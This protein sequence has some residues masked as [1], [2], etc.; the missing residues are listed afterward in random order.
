[1]PSSSPVPCSPFSPATYRGFSKTISGGGQNLPWFWHVLKCA[2]ISYAFTKSDYKTV[3]LPV[4]FYGLMAA[5]TVQRAQILPLI[6]WVWIHLLQFN[7]AN[8]M[9]N[10]EEDSLNKPYRPIPSGLITAQ[11]TRILRWI[12][13]PVCLGISWSYNVFSAGISL[14]LAFIA[15]NEFGLDNYWYTKNFLNA[16][17]LVS[18][19]VGATTIIS[20]AESMQG[21]WLAPW[22]S[23]A[24]I[25]ST[26]HIQDFRD[27]V[28]DKQQGRT[29]FPVVMPEFSRLASSI[30]ILVWSVILPVYCNPNIPAAVLLVFCGLAISLRLM[31]KRDEADD[32][33]SLRVYMFWLTVAQTMPLSIPSVN[34]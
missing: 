7:M 29:T 13:M 12:L 20:G 1:M 11:K 30:I 3:V 32:K 27:V 33:I 16:I 10:S 14:T 21:T 15:Y 26:I 17:G 2:Y 6:F 18:W 24:L 19:N 5:R 22:I 34:A 28:G 23:I 9:S 25:S 31:Y 8:Q 4:I